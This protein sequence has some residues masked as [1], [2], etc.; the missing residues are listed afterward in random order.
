MPRRYIALDRDG[1][2]IV[3]H[4]YLSD[5]DQ[6]Q[7]LPGAGLALAELQSQG[8]GFVIVTNQAGIGRGYF[9]LQRLGEIHVRL[10]AQLKEYNV[11]IDGIYSCPHTPADGCACRKPAIGLLTQAASAHG[12]SPA[13]SIVVGDNICDVELAQAAG[14]TSVL[15]RTGYGSHIEA[16]RAAQPDYVID[17]VW[18]LPTLLRQQIIDSQR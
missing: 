15:V 16:E 18:A 6:V 2:L 17:G 8:Y 3:A 11:T 9:S 7:L 13:E 14:A 10:V 5:P 1:T 12:F 4:N